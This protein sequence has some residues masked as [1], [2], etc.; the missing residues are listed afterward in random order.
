LQKPKNKQRRKTNMKSFLKFTLA[1]TM[2]SM[3]PSLSMA[4]PDDVYTGAVRTYM[5][6]PARDVCFKDTS[7]YKKEGPYT[8]G[9]SNAGLGDSWRVV[10][11][12]SLMKAA[13]ENRCWS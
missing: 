10:G 4:G 11:L 6:N 1:A 9:F 3:A 8:I 2:L 5:Y 7:K 13:A 12:H